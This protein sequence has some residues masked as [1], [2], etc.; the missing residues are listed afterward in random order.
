MSDWRE[1]KLIRE[2]NAFAS[3][4]FLVKL[5]PAD[6]YLKLVLNFW[7]EQLTNT[8]F[9]RLLKFLRVVLPINFVVMLIHSCNYLLNNSVMWLKTH[10]KCLTSV[11]WDSSCLLKKREK[12]FNCN[13]VNCGVGW[14]V[15]CGV[16]WVYEV[17]LSFGIFV[18]W[19]GWGS[20]VYFRRVCL[21][22]F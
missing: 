6:Y 17:V 10:H 16:F 11:Q 5:W 9:W 2:C 12:A 15:A 20:L 19:F 7:C 14:L 21:F 22:I 4:L 18:F 3:T 13:F 1:L 8:A